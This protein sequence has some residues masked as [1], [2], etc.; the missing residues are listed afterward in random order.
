MDLLYE[1]G[2]E[3]IPASYIEPALTALAT[4][5]V[6]RLVEER[7]E[8]GAVESYATP[9]R[10][11]LILRGVAARQ[12]DVEREVLGPA[13]AAA[14]GAGGEPTNAARGFARGQ[15]VPVEALER[16]ETEKGIYVQARVQKIGRPAAEVVPPILAA[17]TRA[18]P[19]P[20]TM[21]WTKSDLRFARPIRWLVALLGDEVLPVAMDG[22]A[23]GRETRGM[24]F[25]RS[26][27]FAVR[28]ADEY[29]RVLAENGVVLDPAARAQSI[30]TG[31]ADEARKAGGKLV[32]DPDLLAE[33][34]NLVAW[35]SVVSG[36]F[37]GDF[38]A[39]PRDVVTTAMRAHQ[40]YFAVEAVA[41]GKLLPRFLCVV[42][43]PLGGPGGL[44]P[45]RVRGGHERVLRA[46]LA[47]ARF[48]WERDSARG[49][50]GREPELAGVV[51]QEGLGSLAD[52]TER[53]RA[54]AA[55]IVESW[56]P[57][58]A[59]VVE[60]AAR[61]AKVDQVSEMVRDG[62]EFT[63]LQGRIG[64]EYARVAG[65][66]GAVCAAIADQYLP[67]GAED[68]L[69]ATLAGSALA[70]ADKLDHVA[71]AFVAGKIP[72]G[73]EDPFAV[74][75]AANGLLR[76][77]VE[78]DRHVSLDR[79]IERALELFRPFWNE[80]DP[81]VV[82]AE[83]RDF[84][85]QRIDAFLAD[86]GIRYDLA[87]ATVHG[88]MDDPADV[89]RR[90]EALAEYSASPDFAPL[91]VGYKRVANIL[92]GVDRVPPLDPKGL[93]EPAER[94]LHA[95]AAAAAGKIREHRAG[96]RFGAAL[97]ELLALRKP[98]DCFF[99][100]VMVMVDEEAVRNRRLALLAEVR[101][102]FTGTWD[103]SR[104]VVEGE[105]SR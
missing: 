55:A 49:V 47:D 18:M 73:S 58:L 32:A 11:T 95:A 81:A 6:T 45:E 36:A 2:V 30:A 23:A 87:D 46:R 62:K 85:M 48:Y 12:P 52:K 33:V 103:L 8:H 25:H 69:P 89:R 42:N 53:L 84:F 9:R 1:I 7:L 65:E 78:A 26:G 93:S 38:L 61:L 66:D 4:A 54:L 64:A 102:L 77:L 68:A 91:V 98:I 15:G 92:R 13:V 80:R 72:S 94:E 70:T 97:A 71:G 31:L 35:P 51:W 50:E 39:L 88:S 3:E 34:A 40:R 57:A 43:G 75:R 44:D 17:A 104:V 101:E 96:R 37:D 41:G 28:N 22:I 56:D 100:D 16:V 19:F 20:R 14:Y 59:P 105:K 74:R 86:R 10:F 60:R 82:R 27:P 67:R 24:R 90:A 83:L 29:L 21:R 79:L 5:V 76:I 99:D 63:G